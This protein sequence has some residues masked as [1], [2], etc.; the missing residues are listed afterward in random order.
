MITPADLVV[1]LSH[2]G[3]A[4]TQPVT[5]YEA[6]RRGAAPGGRLP[7]LLQQGQAANVSAGT[8]DY[9][10][11]AGTAAYAEN[12]MLWQGDTTI[13]ADAI[14]LD[15]RRA[16][17]PASVGQVARDA[18]RHEDFLAFRDLVGF[19]GFRVRGRQAKNTAG[20]KRHWLTAVGTLHDANVTR[21]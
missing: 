6:Q 12:A 2:A 14:L 19:A 9:Q 18:D 5:D 17:Q 7:G 11:V 10:G 16:D 15:Q 8:L 20:D 4:K 13:R 21:G 1:T 3:Y